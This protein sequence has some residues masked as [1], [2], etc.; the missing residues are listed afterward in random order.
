MKFLSFNFYTDDILYCDK[1]YS[2]DQSM[3]PEKGLIFKRKSCY[4]P[5]F[6]RNLEFQ[7]KDNNPE[8][9]IITTQG[10]N[11]DSYLHSDFLKNYFNN[12]KRKYILY[13]HKQFKKINMSIYIQPRYENYYDYLGSDEYPLLTNINSLSISVNSIYGKL[14]FIGIDRGQTGNINKQQLDVLVRNAMDAYIDQNVNFYFIMAHLHD[15]NNI[16]DDYYVDCG[17][18]NLNTEYAIT[19]TND[20]YIETNNNH[21]GLI[22]LY[23][24]TKKNPKILCFNWNT[25][26]TPLCDKIY[27]NSMDKH[28][29]ERWY[30]SDECYNPLFFTTIEENIKLNNPDIVAISSE[31]DLKKGTFF[32]SD[33]LP[34]KMINYYLLTN[35]KVNDIG[36]EE[37]MRMSIYVRNDINDISLVNQSF[38][39]HD[40][41]ECIL[42]K[43]SKSKAL[44]KYVKTYAGIIAFT[45][46]QI[47]DNTSPV[48][49]NECL[50]KFQKDLLNSKLS[51]IFLMGD[52]AYPS[53]KIEGV[54]ARSLNIDTN[55][56]DD[57]IYKYEALQYYDEGN[58]ISPNYPL[59]PITVS[60]RSNYQLDE[61]RY[62]HANQIPIMSWHDRIYYKVNDLTSHDIVC[63]TYNNVLGFPIL[64][65]NSKHLGVIGIYELLPY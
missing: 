24:I 25:D 46:I 40:Y 54:D 4:N 10:D 55:L 53:I 33:F 49:A 16:L 58:Y 7:I 56:Y 47:P 8:L 44:V 32:H 43:Y 37:T 64:H 36:S 38:F 28:V 60:M 19:K 50:L 51:Y 59:K 41:S 30:G 15:I 31:G 23:N 39:K 12:L 48:K 42:S 17:A 26:K 62:E 65:Y 34:K 13:A 14:T 35:D 6:F 52:F 1:I 61:I 63:L 57:F 2:E 21:P 5:L 3:I 27:Q 22:T 9:I 11:K 18:H 45:S 20:E 29:R